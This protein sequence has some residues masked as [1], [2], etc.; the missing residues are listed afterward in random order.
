MGYFLICLGLFCF[1]TL[2]LQDYFIL[3]G[4]LGYLVSIN[5]FILCIEP[6]SSE[7]PDEF[8][9]SKKPCKDSRCLISPAFL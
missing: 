9:P 3:L 2:D 6:I 7:H 1:H 8:I 4:A 5:I